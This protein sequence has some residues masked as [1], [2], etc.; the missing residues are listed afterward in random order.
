MR[1]DLEL[2]RRALAAIL[3]RY[4]DADRALNAASRDMK[5]WIPPERQPYLTA[6]GE[7]GSPIRR[8]YERRERAVLQLQA[9]RLK[10]ETAKRRL[11]A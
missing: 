8:L 2:R 7:P 4:L 9:A 10:L 6:I 3:Q 5:A 1:A 11:D